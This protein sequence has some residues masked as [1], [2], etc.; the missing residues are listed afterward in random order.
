MLY[1]GENYVTFTKGMCALEISEKF[2]VLH[3]Y[4]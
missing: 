1:L 3:T 2:G 4:F